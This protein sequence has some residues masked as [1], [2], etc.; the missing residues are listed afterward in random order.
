MGVL[1]YHKSMF[2]QE[3]I[4][5]E[6]IWNE[7]AFSDIQEM[8]YMIDSDTYQLVAANKRIK[9]RFPEYCKRMKCYKLLY[10][11]N[12]PCQNCDIKAV[13]KTNT[14][15]NVVKEL[16]EQKNGYK[17]NSIAMKMNKIKIYVFVQPLIFPDL[18]RHQKCCKMF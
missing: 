16:V 17:S 6:N 7:K 14:E 10:K 15:V 2:V 9:E 11:I 8:V 3:S 1:W 18:Q 5:M 12:E 13:I 4:L